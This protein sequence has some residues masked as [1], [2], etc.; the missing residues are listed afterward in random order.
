M[1]RRKDPRPRNED[2]LEKRHGKRI[3]LDPNL[4]GCRALEETEQLSENLGLL[5]RDV[6][7]MKGQ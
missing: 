2:N 5:L 3:C 6:V 7:G 4:H 1:R